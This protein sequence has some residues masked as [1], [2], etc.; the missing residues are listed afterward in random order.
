MGTTINVVD[1]EL[2]TQNEYIYA[3]QRRADKP[4]KFFPMSWGVMKTIG[5]CAW[6]IRQNLLGGKARLP[7]I[8][9]PAKLYARF[10]PL[11]YSND[12]AQNVLQWR[13]RYTFDQALDRSLSGEDLLVVN[14][15][16]ESVLSH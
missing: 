8:L 9:V 2:P 10:N 15:I 11:Q 6:W 16:D 3:L 14:K 1:D 7:G 12:F 5:Q 13:S 4:P